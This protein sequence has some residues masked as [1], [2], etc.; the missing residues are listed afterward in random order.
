MGEPWE[1]VWKSQILTYLQ[2]LKEE[3]EPH[4]TLYIWPKVVLLAAST[5]QNKQLYSGGFR[6][7][8]GL[9]FEFGG[10]RLDMIFVVT[11]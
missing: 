4:F 1:V 10:I 6:L 11:N 8:V 2:F 3:Q 5:G 7:G 9:G